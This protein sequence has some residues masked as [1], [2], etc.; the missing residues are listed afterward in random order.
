[1]SNRELDRDR[2]KHVNCVCEAVKNI[3]DIQDEVEDRCATSCF[4][5][6]LSPTN[7]VGD[8]VPFLLTNEKGKLLKAAGNVG[9]NNCFITPFFRVRNVDDCCATLQLLLPVDKQGRVVDF[10]FKH[11]DCDDLCDVF[12]LI[13]TNFCIEVD[14]T[15]FCAIQC[16]DPRLVREAGDIHH[17]LLADEE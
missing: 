5:N 10:S 11:D 3:N 13:K 1:M 12:R 17:S 7:S 6:L 4:E 15:C 9:S 2:F 16:L 8:T 14:L